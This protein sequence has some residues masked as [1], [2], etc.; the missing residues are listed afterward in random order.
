MGLFDKNKIGKDAR[1]YQAQRN[2]DMMK[3][4][5]EQVKKSTPAQSYKSERYLERAQRELDKAKNS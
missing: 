1:V 5:H 3:W 4:Y 2:H